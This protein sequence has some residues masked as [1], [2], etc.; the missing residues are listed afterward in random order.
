MQLEIY[1]C[2]DLIFEEGRVGTRLYIMKEG[3][4]ELF[5]SR[6]MM[7][8]GA[9]HEGVLFGDVAFFLRGIKQV[10]STRASQSCQV[11]QLDRGVWRAL[12]PDQDRI[13]LEKKMFPMM[14]SKYLATSL[15]Y[16]NI[17]KNFELAKSKGDAISSN[18]L[19]LDASRISRQ[20][21]AGG[22]GGKL[23]RMLLCSDPLAL[24]L[25]TFS[26]SRSRLSSG[27]IL[28]ILSSQSRK[29]SKSA[30]SIQDT[31]G[32][33][34]GRMSFARSSFSLMK[35]RP[36]SFAQQA[37]SR[38]QDPETIWRRYAKNL[39]LLRFLE[40]TKS[41][42]DKAL[43]SNDSALESPEG[44]HLGKP[45]LFHRVSMKIVEN[46]AAGSFKKAGQRK[47]RTMGRSE[48]S[49]HR[50]SID[51]NTA[52]M[53]S[54]FISLDELKDAAVSTIPAHSP[55]PNT[56]QA[57]SLVKFGNETRPSSPPQLAVHEKAKRISFTNG[58]IRKN[59]PNIG[60][61]PRPP[62]LHVRS[63]SIVAGAQGLIIKQQLQPQDKE[64]SDVKPAI[65]P[66]AATRPVAGGAATSTSELSLT[67]RSHPFEIWFSAPLPPRFCLE[68]SNFR[69]VWNLVML[70]ICLY[71]ILVVPL[72]IS[73]L[74]EFLVSDES[75]ARIWFVL[76][77]GM[78]LLC[79]A[80][81][82]FKKDYFTYIHKG[83]LVTDQD[84]IRKHYLQNGT[85][86]ADLLCVVP[87][88]LFVLPFLTAQGGSSF[89][90]R[91]SVF[92]INKLLRIIHLHNLSETI[93]RTL[94]YDFKVRVVRPSV[95]YFT[96]FAFDFALGAHW[97]ACF[98][99]SF[100]FA[101]YNE[102][103]TIASW[104]TT[105]G[106]LAFRGCNGLQA[107]ADVPVIVK[108]ARSYHFSMG[109]IT[110]V[111]YSDIAPQ[112]EWET[113]ASALVIITSIMLFGM[114]SGGFF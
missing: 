93:Q 107:I 99:Y 103:R 72:R 67:N 16:S 91:I 106:M 34:K 30:H 41:R 108:Y 38:N 48:V 89:W 100:T 25:S 21:I 113:F 77:Y 55:D 2:G 62:L 114:L 18:R 101:V 88:E 96:R 97:V 23:E 74:Y 10:V 12:W 98:F 61:S 63:K 6:S 69:R 57:T 13:V 64:P 40:D 92:R 90:Y 28:P 45:S 73:F 76:E 14:K 58:S 109:A 17:T 1:L 31:S 86:V 24:A 51:L 47:A 27:R 33:S 19:L 5:S 65:A 46:H 111:S 59:I 32:K 52:D 71:Y 82:I 70:A 35:R 42:V 44:R 84:A 94:I 9:M 37:A 26:A 49:F 60:S 105:A 66:A 15:A 54:K 112:N 11:L 83:E 53:K 3:C 20:Q 8:F 56:V 80:D 87:L 43:V 22:S 78:D 110:T 29:M 104:L 50:H 85:Y 68:S 95:F 7:V 36:S 39:R 75:S 102:E 79:V 4:A 81:F